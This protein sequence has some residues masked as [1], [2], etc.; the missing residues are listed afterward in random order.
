MALDVAGR[1]LGHALADPAP[2]LAAARSAAADR[3]DEEA[4]PFWAGACERRAAIVTA[5][6]ARGR[7]SEEALGGRGMRRPGAR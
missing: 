5:E 3:G 1:Q 7:P 4:V 2:R 6:R